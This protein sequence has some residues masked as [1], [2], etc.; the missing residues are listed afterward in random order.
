MGDVGSLIFLKNDNG[1]KTS[2]KLREIDPKQGF[3]VKRTR[4]KVTKDKLVGNAGLGTIVELFDNSSL[5]KEFAKCLPQRVSNNSKGAYRLA[6]ILLSSLIHG[7]DCL[8]DI[9]AELG[10]NLSAENFFRGKIPASKTI[11]NFLRDFDDDHINKLNKF[12]TE[13]GYQ[14]RGQLKNQLSEEFKPNDKPSFNLDSTPHEQSGD[15]IEGCEYNYKGQWCL[16]SEV[17]YDEMGI[18]YA[19]ILEAGNTKPGIDGPKLLDQVLEPLKQKK[20]DNPFEKVAHVNGDSAYA[21]EEFLRVCMNHGVSFTIAAHGNMNWEQEILNITEWQKWEYSEKDLKKFEKRSKPAPERFVG[22]YHWSPYWAKNLKFPVIIKKEWKA[23]PEFP[24]SGSFRYH[25]VITNEDLFKNSF[26]EVYS[27][28]LTRAF[29]ENSIKESKTNFDA[30]HM[31]CLS[32]KANHAY[33][34]LLL[35]AQ[36][37]LRWVALVTKPE[38]PHYAKKLRRKF[39]FN[40]GKLVSHAGQVCL[41]VTETFKK[42]VDRLVEGWQYNPEIS[43]AF[44]TG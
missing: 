6:L 15:L 34:L 36:N 40:P 10:E 18:C 38:K 16:N 9:D 31:P 7:D 1:S 35:I 41:R 39:I 2:M 4:L 32:F 5:S 37:L 25:A 23:D 14:I 22:R 3:S 44:S 29:I 20:I 28:Y 33:L 8:D 13:M 11:G 12:L 17:V 21:Y 43:S 27:R 19:G 30:Y 26:Q 24:E 42:E